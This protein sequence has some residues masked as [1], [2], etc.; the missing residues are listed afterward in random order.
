MFLHWQT[1][2]EPEI[3]ALLKA[4]HPPRHNNLN[5]CS[6]D[7]KYVILKNPVFLFSFFLPAQQQ[8]YLGSDIGVSQMPLHRCEVYGKACA[9][10]CLA[11]DPYCAWDGTE[12][13]RYFPMAKRYWLQAPHSHLSCH[14]PVI[15]FYKLLN[16]LYTETNQCFKILS[17]FFFFLNVY[18]Q[19]NTILPLWHISR[20]CILTHL[21]WYAH[22]VLMHALDESTH[23][24]IETH[25]NELGCAFQ[26]EISTDVCAFDFC[27]RATCFGF[28]HV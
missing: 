26:M 24:W 27:I 2:A 16:T 10:C 18:L 13:S 9:E 28:K 12:C 5:C 22:W 23:S 3:G 17:R 25:C 20:Y 8:L 7:I 4:R 21:N 19:C 6:K 15:V 1:W 14:Y 11:R